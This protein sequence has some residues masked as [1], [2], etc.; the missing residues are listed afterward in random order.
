LRFLR[1]LIPDLLLGLVLFLLPLAFF[2]SVTLGG[3]TLIPAD[4]LYQY[5]PWAGY[6]DELG[7]PAIPHNALLSDLVLENYQWKLFIRGA[8]GQGELPLWNPYIL[9]GTPFLAAGQH[10]ALYPFSLIYYVLPLPQAYGWFTVSQLWLAGLLMYLFMRGLPMGVGRFP[11]LLAAIIYQLS[12]FFL[13]SVVFQ[14]I[15][16]AAAWLPLLLLMCEY[17]IIRRPLRG[18]RT[19]VPWVAIGAFSLGMCILAG[20]IEFVYYSALIMGGWSAWRLIA[21]FRARRESASSTLGAPDGN[22]RR[23]LLRSVAGLLAMVLLG[24]SIG[25]VQAV[26]LY[27]L[28]S[29]NFRDG[30]ASFETVRSYGYPPRH[31]LAFLMPNFFGSPAEH[32][33][34]DIIDGQIRLFQWQRPDGSS[35]TNTYWEVNKNYVEGACYVGLLTLTLAAFAILAPGRKKYRWLLL[36]LVVL[37]LLFI[38]GTPVYALLYY[39]L[40]GLNQLHS[41]FRWVWPLTFAL[42]ALAGFGAAW[43]GD[44]REAFFGGGQVT[45]LWRLLRPV[46]ISL[47][48]VGGSIAA[49]LI[50]SRLFY[51]TVRNAV[52][53]L[54]LRLAGADT[55]FPNVD[56]FYSLAVKNIGAFSLLLIGCGVVLLLACRNLKTPQV[57]RLP[58]VPVWTVLALTFT[59]LDLTLASIGFNPATDPRW[60]DFEPPAIT[61]LKSQSPANWRY[62]A[63]DAGSTPMNANVSIKYALSDVTGY[64]SIITRQ[65]AEYMGQI[66]TQGLLIYNRIAPV[67]AN[68]LG[69]F[70][71]PALRMLAVQYAVSETPLDSPFLAQVYTDNH[72]TTIYR[73]KDAGARAFI[74]QGGTA[75]ITEARLNQVSVDATASAV[76]EKTGAATLVLADSMYPGWRAFIR[77]KGSPESLETEV[78]IFTYAGN[79]RS[80]TIP[81]G[82][83]TIRFRFTPQSVQI[84]AFISFTA[85]VLILFMLIV[86]AWRTLTQDPSSD[87]GRMAR[88]IAAPIVLS[89]FNRVLDFAFAIIMYRVLPTAAVGAYTYA[90]VIIGWFE[91]LTNFGLNT[92]LTREVAR[93]K[94]SAA[95]YFRRTSLLRLALLL[96]W[97]PVLGLFFAYYWLGSRGSADPLNSTTVIVIVLLYIGIIPS[98]LN[99]GLSALFYAFEKAEIP[100]TFSTITALMS[101]VLRL[102]V[103]LLGFSI[104]GLAG[105]S[106]VLGLITMAMLGWR[107]LPLLRPGPDHGPRTDTPPPAALYR[108]MIGESWPLML[109]HLLATLFFKID[110]V[111]LEQFKGKDVVAQ[112]GMAYKWVDAIGV[113]PAFFTMAMLPLMSRLSAE[114]RPG[115]KRNYQLAVK[116]L[117]AIALPVAVMTTFTAPYLVGLLGGAQYITDGTR[118]LQ[119]M[120]WFIPVG[121][122]NSLT[123]Y[124]L[125]ALNKQRPLRWPFMAG[126]AFNI[127]ANV[128]FIPLF[129]YQASAIVTILSEVVLQIGFYALLRGAIGPIPWVR[130]LGRIGAAAAGMFAAMALLWP[131]APIVAVAAGAAAYP[132]LMLI[133]R[134]FTAEEQA[135]FEPLLPGPLR[136]AI[137]R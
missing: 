16:A 95:L 40:P 78:P 64:D 91:I 123:Q 54:Y 61:Y 118:A 80:V 17:T 84:G 9:A 42:A 62:I 105:A 99:N 11:A 53:A 130:L 69:V 136:R 21:E 112:Y 1:P 56:A 63:V 97:L 128:L 20:H 108:T 47:T 41:P 7:V 48:I 27:E 52:E 89:L 74:V 101:I 109:N 4:N 90:V 83:W 92:F 18:K 115:L 100:A 59:V 86:Y 39:G 79:F 57:G 58:S 127:V 46:G 82:E 25:A 87:V 14:M 29:R 135:R 111:L 66:Q 68:S 23:D 12:A 22:T 70:G 113:I 93:N 44:A 103:L 60:L 75:A 26:P 117:V 132:M 119:L 24:A 6:R 45:R 2:Y 71:S 67:Y 110:V 13:A 15:I 65:Y 129:S 98:S 33:Y 55:Q 8:L 137:A 120:I 50:L 107:A 104:I 31:A 35:V 134:P 51:N 3:K 10:S 77:A 114:D 49:L 19:V 76:D 43:V 5:Q 38:F 121:W 73:V 116:L 122:I 36:A 85:A 72:G 124:V 126:V 81:R 106:V 28:A 34:L 96:L 37:S 133:L 125:I 102:A 88:N 94:L 131:L 32:D 30:S